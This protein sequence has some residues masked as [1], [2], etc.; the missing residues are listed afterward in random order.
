MYRPEAG[1]FVFRVR[2]G[3]RG[4][5]S[6]GV[7][8][9]YTAIALLGLAGEPAEAATGVLSGS[10]PGTVYGRLLDGLDES[11]LG[12]VALTLWAGRALDVP[13]RRLAR[14]RLLAMRPA[15]GARPTVELSWALAAL[16]AEARPEDSSV[17]ERLA[18]RLT[19][20]MPASAPVFPHVIGGSAGLRGHVACFADLVYPIQALSL[21]AKTDADPLSL[22]AAC[23]AADHVC[24][25]QGPQGQW[26]WHYDARTG[27]VI[28]E[29][30]V[31]AV[32]QDSMAPMALFAASAASG[33]DYGD[34][35]LRGLDWLAAAP[36]LGGA[37]LVDEACGIVWR[38]VA[39][40]EPAKLARALQAGASRLHRN[41]RV[42]ALDRIL[43]PRT[44]DDED[45]PYHLGWVLHAWPPPP[46]W[47]GPG[48]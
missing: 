22:D 9:R 7:S 16:S 30:P 34:A 46:G 37:S 15:D 26:W 28:E 19:E 12:D 2:R 36:E 39:R 41:L 21:H 5:I 27:R 3:P 35:I 40:R 17:R 45:R 42:P 38:K 33:R 1:L 11:G 6:E 32:H 20:A 10:S 31:Y 18:R 13:G 47:P 4:L 8:R 14:E 25:L 48:A 24:R 23:R 44:V 29:Y 43:P